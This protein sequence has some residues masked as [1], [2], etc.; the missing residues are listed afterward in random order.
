M[1]TT[2]TVLKSLSVLKGDDNPPVISEDTAGQVT[3]VCQQVR[4]YSLSHIDT[5]ISCVHFVARRPVS[6]SPVGQRTSISSMED[7]HP[8]L[9]DNSKPTKGTLGILSNTLS[10]IRESFSPA[11]DP[12]STIWMAR[13]DHA[14][15]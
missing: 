12:D 8:E 9:D 15:D 5:T 1:M 7:I 6:E 10:N 4:T 14:Y 2:K 11:R 3:G 13:T